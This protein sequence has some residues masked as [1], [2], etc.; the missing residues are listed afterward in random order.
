MVSFE[1]NQALSK[2]EKSIIERLER[3]KFSV[4]TSQR[5]STASQITI[6]SPAEVTSNS[7]LSRFFGGIFK[8]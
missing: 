7:F 6:S 1:L 8:R 5:A 4:L 2:M 3:N